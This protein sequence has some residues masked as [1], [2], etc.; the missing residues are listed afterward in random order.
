[1]A[2]LREGPGR[3]VVAWKRLLT[4]D[5]LLRLPDDGYRYEL[6]GG[7]LLNEPPAGEEHGLVAMELARGAGPGSP[8][9]WAIGLSSEPRQG[10]R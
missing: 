6:M 5:D 4:A 8:A 10:Q 7:K 3:T 2:E 1:M 9:E